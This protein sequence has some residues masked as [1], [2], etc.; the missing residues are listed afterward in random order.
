MKNNLESWVIFSDITSRDLVDLFRLLLWEEIIICLSERLQRENL[1][2]Q[3][4]I[5]A[6]STEI[7]WSL[8][9]TTY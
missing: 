2:H 1:G 5:A 4:Q 6:K 8:L 3:S 7:N 9:A